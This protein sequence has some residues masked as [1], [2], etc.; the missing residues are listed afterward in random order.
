MAK[1]K[2]RDQVIEKNK[3]LK[4]SKKPEEPVPILDNIEQANIIG[5]DGNET[6]GWVILK[7]VQF[8]HVNVCMNEI[9]DDIKDNL[10]N[11]LRR[12]NDDFGVT[13]SGNPVTK[14]IIDHLQKVC[15][16]IH[17]HRIQSQPHDPNSQPQI[18][19]QIG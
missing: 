4:Q 12:T 18:D 8:K 6:P 14:E 1:I 3:K 15:Q 5:P 10:V 19:A 2:A 17:I 11:V 13:L 9:G 7:N 16:E